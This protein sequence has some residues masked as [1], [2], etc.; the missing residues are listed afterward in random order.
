MPGLNL[1]KAPDWPLANAPTTSNSRQSRDERASLKL[2][3]M[4][5]RLPSNGPWMRPRL[6]RAGR[7]AA[8]TRAPAGAAAGEIGGLP[9]SAARLA[10]TPASEASFFIPQNAIDVAGRT[11]RSNHGL[12]AAHYFGRPG[13]LSMHAIW[14]NFRCCPASIASPYSSTTIRAGAVRQM[15][16][17]ARFAGFWQVVKQ[18]C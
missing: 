8:W 18:S 6:D 3:D 16:E 12:T 5:C 11:S 9:T 2:Q 7:F 1:R 4:A 17:R 13:P 14:R 10:I 15:R